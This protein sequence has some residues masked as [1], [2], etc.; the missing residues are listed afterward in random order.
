VALAR[1]ISWTGIGQVVRQSTQFIVGITLARLLTPE[2]FGLVALTVVFTG[3][4]ALFADLGLGAALIQRPDITAEDLDFVFWLNLCVAGAVTVAVILSAPLIAAFYHEPR[5]RG[6]TQLLG[7]CPL[8]GSL[9]L[10]PGSLMQKLA[11]FRE[12]AVIDVVA[13]IV[14]GGIACWCAYAGCGAMSLIVQALA[15][16]VLISAFRLAVV[17]WHPRFHLNWSKGRRLLPFGSGLLGSNAVN[18]WLRNGDNLLVGKF[19]GAVQLGLYA[20]A[21]S[22]L[23]LPV[24][25][26]QTVLGPVVFPALAAMQNSK[27]DLRRVF[28]FANQAIAVLAFPLMIGLAVVAD[29]FVK[30][31]LGIHWTGSIPIIRVLALV[32]VGQSIGTTTGWIYMSIGRTDRML[33][34]VMIA[35]P[36]LVVSFALGVRWG[37]LGVSIGYAIATVVLWYPQW[38]LAGSLIG[39]SF[40]RAMAN[41]GGPLVC[42]LFMAFCVLVLRLALGKSMAPASRL[43]I[44]IITGATSYIG[45]LQIVRVPAYL[46]MR[47]RVLSLWPGLRKS[48]LEAAL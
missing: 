27:S 24:L 43:S 2:E 46:Y 40:R 7:L 4:A 18:Y 32:A 44:V 17:K 11:R 21:Y 20:R 6:I 47:N 36:L 37:G 1:H 38:H 3:F 12:L 5:L 23:M 26:V 13:V 42:S 45:A 8:L 25:Q 33:R 22:L 29:D 31:L 35:S 28:L 41:V 48:S 30:V 39:L 34:W 15:T 16:L 9:G 14:S 10:V 19:C